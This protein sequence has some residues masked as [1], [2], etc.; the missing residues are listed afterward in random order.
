M[1]NVLSPMHRR[2]NASMQVLHKI[3]NKMNVEVVIAKSDIDWSNI[4]LFINVLIFLKLFM[5]LF[6]KLSNILTI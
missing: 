5:E 4:Y 3:I 6:M 2:L 1:A